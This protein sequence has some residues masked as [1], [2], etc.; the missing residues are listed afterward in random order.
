M[1]FIIGEQIRLNSFYSKQIKLL[2]FLERQ[3]FM[4]KKKNRFCTV[5]RLKS[6]NE[7]DERVGIAEKVEEI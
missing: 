6:D 3:M 4:M 2:R 1:K 5:F 7:N